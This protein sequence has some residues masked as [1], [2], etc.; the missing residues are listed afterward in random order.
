MIMFFTLIKIYPPAGRKHS[1]VDV[2]DSLKGPITTSTHCIDCTIMVETGRNGAVCYTEQWSSR[3]AL[4]QH[5]RSALFSRILEAM[6]CS[7]K[8]PKLSFFELS[9]VG[10]LEMVEQARSLH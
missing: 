4:E 8:P 1:V 3:E 5:L 6:E 10:G 2:L 7:H 9:E